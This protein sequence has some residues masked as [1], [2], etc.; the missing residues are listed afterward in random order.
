MPRRRNDSSGFLLIAGVAAIVILLV[1]C[2]SGSP[3]GAG[4]ILRSLFNNRQFLPQGVQSDVYWRGRHRASLIHRPIWPEHPGYDQ[5][6]HPSV[7]TPA[8]V[9]P[10]QQPYYGAQATNVS[11]LESQFQQVL[12]AQW[13]RGL[14]E[15]NYDGGSC[16]HASAITML[17]YL[18][19]DE[20]AAWWRQTYNRGEYAGRMDR[21][22]AEAGL[23][24]ASITSGDEQFLDWACGNLG[25]IRRGACVTLKGAHVLN[26]IGLTQTHAYIIDNNRPG[27]IETWSRS[28]FLR[29]WRRRGGWAFVIL[30]GAPPPPVPYLST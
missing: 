25:G 9:A 28:A 10:H 14:R 23:T 15:R 17:R 19:K 11:G 8:P 1:A 30:D 5:R 12:N 13:A 24:F 4:G 27:R 3:V 6:Y 18:G 22:M 20:L 16:V 29:D 7:Y 2:K 26:L 21:R